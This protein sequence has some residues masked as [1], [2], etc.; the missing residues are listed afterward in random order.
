MS[1]NPRRIHITQRCEW[2]CVIEFLN[3]IARKRKRYSFVVLVTLRI[4]HNIPLRASRNQ[5]TLPCPSFNLGLC[6][7]KHLTSL[8]DQNEPVIMNVQGLKTIFLYGYDF[9]T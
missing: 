6:R 2:M 3:N 9:R 4:I 1:Q 7:M 5:H 8:D